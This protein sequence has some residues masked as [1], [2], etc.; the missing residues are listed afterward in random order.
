[1]KIL[2]IGFLFYSLC[3]SMEI[4]WSPPPPKKRH[5]HK[6]TSKTIRSLS[7]SASLQTGILYVVW[8]MSAKEFLDIP[9]D[10]FKKFSFKKLFISLYSELNTLDLFL[11]IYTPIRASCIRDVTWNIYDLS[12]ILSKK[13]IT[14]I[15]SK[16]CPK[17]TSYWKF[18]GF[19]IYPEAIFYIESILLAENTIHWVVTRFPKFYLGFMKLFF[20]YIFSWNVNIY[21]YS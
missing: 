16:L 15:W 4:C 6:Q 18:S 8:H 14:H 1:M 5:T 13:F 12:R 19:D 21:I 10:F 9:F 20:V 11:Y 17:A 7:I 2:S 3:W